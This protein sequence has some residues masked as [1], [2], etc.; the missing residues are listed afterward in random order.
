M[1]RHVKFANGS[2]PR[3]L[4]GA[5][6][7]CYLAGSAGVLGAGQSAGNA[8]RSVW[9]GVFTAEQADRGGTLYAAS[10][11]GCHGGSLQGGEGKSLRG[12]AFWTDWREQTVDA[13]LTYVSKNMPFSEDGSLAGTLSPSTYADIVAFMLSANELPAGKQELTA[14]SSAGVMIIRKDGPGELPATTLARVGGCLAP[15]GADGSWVLTRG[16]RPVRASE[17]KPDSERD[18]TLGDR[19]YQLKF[20]LTS[21]AKQVGH[22]VSVTGA[23][24]GDGGVDGLN[25]STVMS[26]ADTCN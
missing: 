15:R 21:L 6:L 8:G 4:L 11:A 25:V 26:V 16:T 17:A 22:R 19:T 23:L 5:A 24:M 12:E 20:V 18:A 7:V 3:A 13:L 14:S 9:D 1:M 10:C 2:L